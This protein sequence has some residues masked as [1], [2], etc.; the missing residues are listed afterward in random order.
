[1][2]AA[3]R[4]EGFAPRRESGCGTR[5]ERGFAIVAVVW[6]V[7]LLSVMALDV[8]AAAR[9]E[10]GNAETSIGRAQLEAAAD[11][12]V[13]LATHALLSGAREIPDVL[14]FDGTALSIAVEDETGK[15]DLNAANPRLLRQLFEALEV[16]SGRAEALVA[17]LED[18]RDQDRIARPRGGAE[19]DDYRR[20]GRLAPPRDGVL[21]SVEELVEVVGFTPELVSRA[22]PALTVYT[23]AA[24]PDRARAGPLVLASLGGGPA[25][26]PALE[27]R[28]PPATGRVV[29][30]RVVAR[31]GVGARLERVA[32]VRLTG[33]PREP[34]YVQ[35]WW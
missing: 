4:G 28:P 32:V 7:A 18:W 10:A 29:S 27:L 19:F 8:L 33:N 22:A 25:G 34:V 2:S 1:M 14:E 31:R 3:R 23:R 35:G 13:A 30:I 15:I 17:A 21:H 16:P 20:A 6:A 11:A 9:R 24:Q 26:T 12:G 5:G